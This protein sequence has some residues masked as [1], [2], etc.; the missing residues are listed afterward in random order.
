[1]L[2]FKRNNILL[3][4]EYMLLWL[5]TVP[6]IAVKPRKMNSAGIA[7]LARTMLKSGQYAGAPGWANAASNG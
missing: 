6:T 4:M 3:L 5:G 2:Y 1:M 7:L